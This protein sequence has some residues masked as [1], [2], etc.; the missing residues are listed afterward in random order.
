[1]SAH[2]ASVPPRLAVLAERE[3]PLHPRAGAYGPGTLAFGL[4]GGGPPAFPLAMPQMTIPRRPRL[5]RAGVQADGHARFHIRPQPRAIGPQRG[6][7]ARRRPRQDQ[8]RAGRAGYH[9][10]G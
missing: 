10:Q 2:Y 4:E 6:P 7:R 8:R 9:G 3:F 5:P 1:M